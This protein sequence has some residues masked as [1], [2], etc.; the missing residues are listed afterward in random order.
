MPR[1]MAD[2]Q[3]TRRIQWIGLALLAVTSFWPTFHFTAHPLGTLRVD[4]PPSEP[5]DD[6]FP[7][8]GGRDVPAES[9]VAAASA[10]TVQATWWE[11]FWAVRRWYPWFLWPV[12]ALAL[13]LTGGTSR[14]GR[15]RTV[16]GLGMLLFTLALL[17]FEAAY[18]RAEYVAFLPGA[19]GR[20]EALAAWLLVAC[21]L[22]W[23]RASDRHL[24]AL[25]ATVAAHALLGCAH[26]LTLP[27]TMARQWWGD[28]GADRVIAAV[29]ANFP[30]A[31]WMGLGALALVAAPVYLRRT[32]DRPAGSPRVDSE[33]MEGLPTG[34]PEEESPCAVRSSPSSSP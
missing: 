30:P 32:G 16:I 22:L 9:L 20:A 23:R 25:E 24:G 5:V 17:A 12:W 15:R 8:A 11:P 21:L 3:R 26:A 19:L 18:L 6:R 14:G 4:H 2:P 33:S 29:W 10:A 34:S 27:S 28:H 1:P 31:F 13:L 7:L